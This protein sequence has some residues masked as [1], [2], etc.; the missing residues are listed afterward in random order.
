MGD[1][2][3]ATFPY[4]RIRQESGRNTSDAIKTL[5]DLIDAEITQRRADV[6]TAQQ[7]LA[8]KVV[9]ETFAAQQNDYD[10][11]GASIVLSTG[12]SAQTITGFRAPGP[13]QTRILFCH[14]I[15]AGTITFA[16]ANAASATEH[17]LRLESLANTP[18]AT[19]RSI[20]FLYLNLRWRQLSLV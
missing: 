15:G 8:P 7:T 4:E 18:V 10:L 9:S 19:D 11:A 13:S 17:Q 12:A 6:R 5:R 3:V 2:Q 1:Q 20:V 14:V 16:H